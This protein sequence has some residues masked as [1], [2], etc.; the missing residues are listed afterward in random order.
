MGIFEVHNITSTTMANQVK[1][2]IYSSSLF[3]KVSAYV[4]DKRLKLNTLILTL[5]SVITCFF[6]N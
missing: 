5:T 1:A 4:K 3:D 6:F 2:L